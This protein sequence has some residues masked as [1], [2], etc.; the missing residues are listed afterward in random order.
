MFQL[1]FSLESDT[2]KPH[3]WMD[4]IRAFFALFDKVVYSLIII[5]YEILFNLA[6]ATIIQSE[7]MVNFY[8]RVQLI[9][10]VYMIFKVSIS[11]SKI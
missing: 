3:W 10:G 4:V 8:S 11:L 1:G 6:D 5:M 7:T 2:Q 9:I